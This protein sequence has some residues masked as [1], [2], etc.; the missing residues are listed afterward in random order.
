MAK[1]LKATLNGWLDRKGKFYPCK[2][3]KHND[4]EAK[5]SKQLKLKHGLEYS[6]WVKVHSSGI[7][8]FKADEYYGRQ[9]MRVTKAQNKWLVKNGYEAIETMIKKIKAKLRILRDWFWYK[10]IM[11]DVV[12][13]TAKPRPMYNFGPAIFNCPRGIKTFK[14]NKAIIEKI[15]KEVGCKVKVVKEGEE[16][17]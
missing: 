16:N 13:P 12:K 6:G 5:L 2:F 17:D 3:N 4:A 1:S 7:A 10:L 15:A 8:F 11:W 9:Y 14:Y